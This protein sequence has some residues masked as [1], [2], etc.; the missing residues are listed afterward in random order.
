M[1]V[2]FVLDFGGPDRHDPRR[3]PAFYPSREITDYLWQHSSGVR[4]YDTAAN[5]C[6][7]T[8]FWRQAMARHR[9]QHPWIVIYRG[10]NVL[11][12]GP[13]PRLTADVLALLKK[14]GQ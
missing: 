14:Q 8:L 1:R 12:E 11:H 9:S 4:V 7:E 3:T 13:L 10:V 2:L 5:V 6:D